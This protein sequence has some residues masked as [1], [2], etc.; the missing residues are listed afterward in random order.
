MGTHRRPATRLRLAS[1]RGHE[2]SAVERA[3]GG[4]LARPSDSPRPTARS[5]SGPAGAAH[6]QGEPAP[7][8]VAAALATGGRPL[9]PSVRSQAER[10]WGAPLGDVRVHTGADAQRGASAVDAYAYTVGRDV[11]LGSP[12]HQGSGPSRDRVLAH[13]L[14]HLVHDRSDGVVHRYRRKTSMAFG[15]R[16]ASVPF[17]GGFTRAGPLLLPIIDV[18]HLVE[19]DFNQRTDKETKPWIEQVDV[20]FDGTATDADGHVFTT[21][22]ASARYHKSPVA[23]HDFTFRV[24]GGSGRMRTDPG[25]FTVLRIEGYG[26]NSGSASGR[27]GVDF[28]WSDREPNRPGT[29]D[30][31]YTKKEAGTGFR[32]AN[33]SFAVFYNGGEAL[34]AGPLDYTSHGCVH[35]DW[36]DVDTGPSLIQ[37]LN[38]HSVVG[39]TKVKV[40]YSSP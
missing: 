5:L 24:S 1:G 18:R 10:H 7:P 35:V 2:E 36:S 26:Y 39:L 6:L 12:N 32:L 15:E 37:Q 34:H 40:S 3:A 27:P 30:R 11:V 14:A 23:W 13:E 25:S 19:D 9:E 21:G 28:Q 29:R 22:T 31:N 33:M 38:Y 16:D 17:I 4:L 20:V 8:S